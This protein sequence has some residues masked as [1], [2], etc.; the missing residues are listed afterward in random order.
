MDV[1]TILQYVLALFMVVAGVNHFLK[2]RMYMR[3]MPPSLPRPRELVLVSGVAEVLL[4]IF[5]LVPATTRLAA[6]GLVALFVAV[7]PANLYMAQHPEHFRKIPRALLWL[8]L[9]LQAVLILWALWY[10]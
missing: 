5:L 9:P 1:K 6:W 4:G 3:I 2:P 7:F 10:T 8:R